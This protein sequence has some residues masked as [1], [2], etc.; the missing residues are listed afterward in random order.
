M[1]FPVILVVF[2]TLPATLSAGSRDGCVHHEEMVHWVGGDPF[3]SGYYEIER[4]DDIVYLPGADRLRLVDVSDPVRPSEIRELPLPDNIRFLRI[5]EDVMACGTDGGLVFFDISEPEDP[6]AFWQYASVPRAIA[7]A[8]DRF[9]VLTASTIEAY[10]FTGGQVPQLTASSSVT[11]SHLLEYDTDRLFTLE[12][13][14]LIRCYDVQSPDAI[15]ARGAHQLWGVKRLVARDRHVFATYVT[16]ISGGRLGAIDATDP[17]NLVAVSSTP[18]YCGWLSDM[19]LDGD[20]I[21]VTSG[22]DIMAAGFVL[23]DISD[24]VN[25]Q[26][27]GRG[28]TPYAPHGITVARPGEVTLGMNRG[29]ALY[30]ATSRN[31]VHETAYAWPPA[32][33]YGVA[34][35][36]NRAYTAT[37]DGFAVWDVTDPTHP[38]ALGEPMWYYDLRA[39]EQD[40]EVVVVGSQTGEVYEIDISDPGSPPVRVS[41]YIGSDPIQAIATSADWIATA[42]GTAGLTL[43]ERHLGSNQP[44]VAQINSV[45]EWGDVIPDIR[46]VELSGQ[47]LVVGDWNYGVAVLSIHEDGSLAPV[48]MAREV[49]PIWTV[50]ASGDVIYA[51]G[52]DGTW[53]SSR[54][55]QMHTLRLEQ[56]GQLTLLDTQQIPS[57]ASELEIVGDLLYL[58][59]PD[60]GVFVYS[61]AEGVI[62]RLLGGAAILAPFGNWDIRDFSVGPD[63]IF[64]AANSGGLRVLPAECS[65][66]VLEEPTTRVLTSS[67][68][69]FL[70]IQPNPFNPCTKVSFSLSSGG[71]TRVDIYDVAGAHIRTLVNEPLLRG[72][73]DIVWDG[74]DDHGRPLA[75]GTYFARLAAPDRHDVRKVMLMK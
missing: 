74:H 17:D 68:D 18:L 28:D 42:H 31:F 52:G 12:D 39:L 49:G 60:L 50:A 32:P 45:A 8:T 20:C 46:D 61:L 29:Y 62:P 13:Y 24:P 37:S 36:G 59:M 53:A 22:N 16:N 5:H 30:D 6:R 11:S 26:W 40:G 38:A 3:G 51:A 35:L 27:L 57:G 47:H 43:Y 73:H 10:A 70:S 23:M 72:P 71:P 66:A 58:G 48:S 1:R 9:F 25:P 33:L 7:F 44:P 63:Y 21:V 69:A 19:D 54:R 55:I 41:S 2:L 67:R 65:N 34:L 75:S 64:V 56:D 4:K 14:G 15:V